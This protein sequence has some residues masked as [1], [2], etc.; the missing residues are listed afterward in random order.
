MRL[1]SFML[2]ACL[3]T[4]CAVGGTFAKY[5][6]SGEAADSA[7]VAKWGV[8]VQAKVD[9]TVATLEIGGDAENEVKAVA[10]QVLLA[11]GTQ[12]NNLADF[13]ISGTPEVAVNVS[14]VATLTLTGWA[15]GDP[16][17]EYCPLVFNVNDDDY[18]IDGTNI[19]TV[20]EL[21][22]AVENAINALSANYAVS[23]TNLSDYAKAPIVS[24]SWAFA[25]EDAKDTALGNLATA[26][27]MSLTITATVTQ[28]D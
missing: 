9:T 7:R 26:P 1:A 17:E 5:V 24:V 27:T 4:C 13:A 28:I 15:F 16:A 3:A 22:T 11:P 2:I 25:G 20:A 14:Y 12:I 8:T 10:P 19:K 21:K 6:T 23:D 18:M